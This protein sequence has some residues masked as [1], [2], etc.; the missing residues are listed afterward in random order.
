[1]PDNSGLVSAPSEYEFLRDYLYLDIDKVRSIAGQ[2]EFGIPEELRSTDTKKRKRSLGWDKIVSGSN[3]KTEENYLQRSVVDSLF[4][5]LELEL[6]DG[7][8]VDITEQFKEGRPQFE[9]IK[10]LDRKDPSSD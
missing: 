2:L 7:W 1:M 8:L 5:E 4:P 3:E 6:A 10:S 9:N